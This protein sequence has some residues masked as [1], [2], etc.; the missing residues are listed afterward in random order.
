[1][2][3]SLRDL[4]KYAKT[5]IPSEKMRPFDKLFAYQLAGGFSIKTLSGVPPIQFISDGTPLTAWGVSGAS[6]GV[7]DKTAQLI[8]EIVQGGV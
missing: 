2:R 3:A 5:G 8:P 7:G 1:M 6:G 4:Y